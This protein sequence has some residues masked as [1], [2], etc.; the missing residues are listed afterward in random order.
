MSPFTILA[1]SVLEV[2]AKIFDQGAV[3]V[4]PGDHA[5]RIESW[6]RSSFDEQ[7]HAD[8][9]APGVGHIANVILKR[10]LGVAGADVGR[11]EQVK[12][13]RSV[14]CSFIR[15]LTLRPL[16]CV[17]PKSEPYWIQ[18]WLAPLR[19]TGKPL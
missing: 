10:A 11:G 12:C 16:I 4:R 13:G 6:D 17:L 15:G 1:R 3:R 5:A 8:A 9:I 14:V 7:P 19:K 2:G 18:G